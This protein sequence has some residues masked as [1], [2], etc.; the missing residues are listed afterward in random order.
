MRNAI[1]AFAVT[2]GGYGWLIKL[3][4]A[5]GC[6]ALAQFVTQLLERAKRKAFNLK[7]LD[8]SLKFENAAYNKLYFAGKYV[9]TLNDFKSFNVYNQ[10]GLI[11][12]KRVGTVLNI[13]QAV[14]LDRNHYETNNFLNPK[15]FPYF[16]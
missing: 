1:Q 8:F 5:A 12:F 13:A 3:S 16:A 2:G 10:L 6:A 14:I 15:D 4:N 11:S 9:K 7:A